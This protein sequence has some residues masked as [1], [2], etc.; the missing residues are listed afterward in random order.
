M[1]SSQG[2]EKL[3]GSFSIA[4]V[5]GVSERDG[6]LDYFV[7]ELLLVSDKPLAKKARIRRRIAIRC[8]SPRITI[9]WASL[10]SP[11][12]AVYV[13]RA[14]GVV[15]ADIA[16]GIDVS[17]VSHGGPWHVGYRKRTFAE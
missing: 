4:I 16:A 17:V 12:E 13:T 2:F 3:R 5:A 14:V 1:D 9:L 15:P 8:D 11:H 10:L 7:S 6:G